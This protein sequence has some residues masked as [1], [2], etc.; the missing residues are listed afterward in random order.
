[1]LSSEVCFETLRP[2][3]GPAHAPVLWGPIF[4]ERE[5]HNDE[6]LPKARF[7]LRS[8]GERLGTLDEYFIAVDSLKAAEKN[9]DV[10]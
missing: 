6:I 5:T 7:R 3:P 9:V 4:D 10:S 2:T 8:S 1:M